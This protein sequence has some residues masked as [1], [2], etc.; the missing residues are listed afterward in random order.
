[1]FNCYLKSSG[2]A[3]SAF[4]IDNATAAITTNSYL[5]YETDIV[6][7]GD[8]TTAELGIRAEDGQGS[9]AEVALTIVVNNVN[10]PPVFGE[11]SYTGS[12]DEEQSSG[13]AVTLGTAISTT[14]EN[15]DSLT[16]S[17]IGNCNL[18]QFKNMPLFLIIV[19]STRLCLD[20]L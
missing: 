8:G 2:N 16:Y 7:Y 15:G 13:A 10:E 12:V 19:I 11:A 6:N 3:A 18:V 17:L 5:D 1:M 20:T 9:T 14:D 4:S